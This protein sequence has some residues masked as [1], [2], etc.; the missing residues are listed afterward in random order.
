[1]RLFSII[2]RYIMKETAVTFVFTVCAFMFILYVGAFLKLMEMGLS[3]GRIAGYTPFVLLAKLPF[4]LPLGFI[5]GYIITFSRLAADRE[6]QIIRVSGIPLT[7]VILPH[8]VLAFGV[9]LAA[10]YTYQ[11]II[12]RI[13]RQFQR[14]LTTIYR[15]IPPVTET[16]NK[17]SLLLNRDRDRIY[18]IAREA[19]L[20]RGLAIQRVE[21]GRLR[22]VTFAEEARVERKSAGLLTF[23]MTRVSRLVID[24]DHIDHPTFATL[25]VDVPLRNDPTTAAAGDDYEL[26]TG[27]ELRAL[28]KSAD[29]TA[30]ARRRAQLEYWLRMALATSCFIFT[31]FAVPAGILADQKSRASGFL[32]SILY[33]LV[34][35]FPLL[36]GLRSY[37]ETH[38]GM[39]PN[40]LMVPNWLFLFIGLHLLRKVLRA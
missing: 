14:S 23:R 34:I 31:L 26:M 18:V 25:T 17:P 8:L 36:M 40:L 10:I 19:T 12:P 24:D 16:Y 5:A 28:F 22:E 21:N 13:N 30:R 6:I 29:A 9:T 38:T 33:A 20:L 2:N 32:R 7:R 1:M 35:Y 4:V 3:F 39:H 11:E 15:E 27:T 37:L